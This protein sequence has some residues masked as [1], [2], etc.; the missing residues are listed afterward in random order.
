MQAI[1]SH[2]EGTRHSHHIF[3]AVFGL[4]AALAALAACFWRQREKPTFVNLQK[5]LVLLLVYIRC[6]L[7]ARKD[8][9]MAAKGNS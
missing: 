2:C 4:G 3:K 7:T 1:L 5:S 8:V 6:I 9:I